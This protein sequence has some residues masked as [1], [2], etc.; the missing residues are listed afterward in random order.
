MLRVLLKRKGEYGYKYTVLGRDMPYIFK[1]YSD[2]NKCLSE[3][4]SIEMLK[5]LIGNKVVV[6]NAHIC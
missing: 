5:I 3:T 6:I 4:D 2:A 1:M